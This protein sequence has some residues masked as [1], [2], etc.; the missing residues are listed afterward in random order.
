[1]WGEA[2]SHDKLCL[3]CICH[4]HILSW[5]PSVPTIL[6]CF[7]S[8]C[9]LY[10]LACHS[11]VVCT[12]KKNIYTA[13]TMCVQQPQWLHVW[14]LMVWHY[15]NTTSRQPSLAQNLRPLGGGL[16]LA[17][18]RWR[19]VLHGFLERVGSGWILAQS[20]QTPRPPKGGITASSGIYEDFFFMA[21]LAEWR[22][23]CIYYADL[24]F[25]LKTTE[26]RA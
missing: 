13:T 21:G 15:P 1:M 23:F 3:L 9:A 24:L 17:Q 18:P 4:I 2:P 22:I 25:F 8:S 5:F 6:T 14:L 20:A 19:K 10:I 26:W 16:S 11:C 12:P 7:R